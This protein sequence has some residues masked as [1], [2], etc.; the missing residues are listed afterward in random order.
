MIA[1]PQTTAKVVPGFSIE[2]MEVLAGSQEQFLAAS[3]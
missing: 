2:P 3:E 1:S